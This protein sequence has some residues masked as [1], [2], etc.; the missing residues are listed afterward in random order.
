M[1]LISLFIT[2][3]SSLLV[4]QV[5]AQISVND[6]I[7]HFKAAERPLQNII[8]KNSAK[9]VFYVTATVEELSE[10][11][12]DKSPLLVTEDLIVSP[13]KFSIDANSER[14]VRLLSRKTHDNKE[15]VYRVS[16]VPQEKEFGE[17]L[18]GASGDRKT[19]IRVITGMGVLVFIDPINPKPEL[20]WVRTPDSVIFTNSGNQHTRLSEGKACDSEDVGCTDLP[21]RRVY[22]GKDYTVSV[23]ANKTI[24]YTRRDGPSG[25]FKS[26]VVAP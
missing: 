11:S 1:K 9:E 19:M 6:V 15:R 12:E 17:P 5:E 18:E 22:G 20:K 7:V 25:D 3:L 26:I 21:S 14:V 23:P 4:Q 24:Y 8:V 2:L 10:P 16:F 13:K